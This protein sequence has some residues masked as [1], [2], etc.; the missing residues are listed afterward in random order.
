MALLDGDRFEGKFR[1][2]V[3]T[4]DAKDL[5]RRLVKELLL[6]F[7]GTPLFPERFAYTVNYTLSDDEAKLYKEVTSTCGSSSTWRTSWAATGARAPWVLH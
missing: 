3:H 5:M 4:T 6:K 7:D 2:G 1:D